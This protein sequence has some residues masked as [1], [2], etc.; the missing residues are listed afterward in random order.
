MRFLEGPLLEVMLGISC[1][2]SV[3]LDDLNSVKRKSKRI[4][5]L[6]RKLDNDTNMLIKASDA[7][8]VDLEQ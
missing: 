7:S 5:Q 2:T 3:C 6:R 8:E 1:A 4:T